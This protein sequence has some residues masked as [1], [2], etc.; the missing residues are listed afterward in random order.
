MIIDM[1]MNKI[2]NIYE[3]E[4]GKKDDLE[5][6]HEDNYEYKSDDLE[7]I[8]EDDKEYNY[9]DPDFKKKPI[10]PKKK[11]I[12]KVIYEH[13]DAIY[14]DNERYKKDKYYGRVSHGAEIE[15]MDLR[16]Y[17]NEFEL[18]IIKVK[19]LS[20]EWESKIGMICWVSLKD[21]S[22]IERFN[23]QTRTIEDN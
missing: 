12:G 6:L 10:I 4:R 2:Y 18:D 14:G 15:L 21:T 20:N 22:F 11:I 16:V 7:I 23:L 19:V 8:G 17:K 13:G 1:I 9:D 3:E 5:N